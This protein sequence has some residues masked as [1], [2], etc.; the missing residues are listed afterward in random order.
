MELSG[1]VSE[2]LREHD[3]LK[4]IGW[5][6]VG[7]EEG[8]WMCPPLILELLRGRWH[9]SLRQGAPRRAWLGLGRKFMIQSVW[10]SKLHVLPVILTYTSFFMRQQG[11]GQ[12]AEWRDTR[13]MMKMPFQSQRFSLVWTEN[14]LRKVKEEVEYAKCTRCHS[15]TA[16][17]SGRGWLLLQVWPTG[18]CLPFLYFFSEGQGG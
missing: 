11:I 4:V 14:T 1:P 10:D 13:K 8:T 17:Y 3:W 5:I 15:Q 7:R 9:C 2:M 18:M 12:H 16:R 6:C